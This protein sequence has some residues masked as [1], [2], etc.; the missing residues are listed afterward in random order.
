MADASVRGGFA[1]IMNEQH[2]RKYHG[3]PR[4]QDLPARE[5]TGVRP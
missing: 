5:L 2:S 3:L 1:A 4:R